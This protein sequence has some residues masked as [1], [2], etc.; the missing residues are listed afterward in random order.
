MEEKDIW[1]CD[2][3]EKWG[4]SFVKKL[5][6]LA[7]RADSSNLQKIKETWKE[8]WLEYEK[9]GKQWQKKTEE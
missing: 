7:R 8:Y 2:A 5:G 4:G 3:M 9:L 6:E 1:T